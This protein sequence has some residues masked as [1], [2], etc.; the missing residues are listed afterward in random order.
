MDVAGSSA[1]RWQPVGYSPDLSPISETFAVEPTTSDLH[2]TLSCETFCPDD[3]LKNG[4]RR[5]LGVQLIQS[6]IRM[7][8]EEPVAELRTE[9]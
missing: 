1:G 3:Y 4:D 9:K 6:R 2:L 8:I 5:T 7:E